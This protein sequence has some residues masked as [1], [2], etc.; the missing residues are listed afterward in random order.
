M[1]LSLSRLSSLLL[2][3][4]SINSQ[5]AEG[6]TDAADLQSL[7]A[8][9]PQEVIVLMISQDNCGYCVRVKEDYLKPM[10]ASGAHPPIRVLHLGKSQQVIDF[11]G[12]TRSSDSIAKRLGGRF[13]PTL[14]FVDAKGNTLH[15]P[16][17]GLTTPDF[18]SYYLDEAIADSRK[19]IN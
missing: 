10:L 9:N 8:S 15:D 1:P 16:I 2:L 18:Y 12:E 19:R 11:D 4:F 6:L 5:A 17:V 7:G 3:L 13:T 14:L